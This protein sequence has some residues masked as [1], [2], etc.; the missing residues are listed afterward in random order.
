MRIASRSLPTVGLNRWY[1]TIYTSI[2]IE[3][4]IDPVEGPFETLRYK[5]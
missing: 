1:L 4:G 5:S 2:T 3:N